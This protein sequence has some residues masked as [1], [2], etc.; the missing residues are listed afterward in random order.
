MK[1]I[2]LFTLIIVAVFVCLPSF[3]QAQRDPGG[4]PDAPTEVPFD[5]GLTLIIAAGAGY[6]IKKARDKRKKVLTDDTIEK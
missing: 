4:D 1:K 3:V 2:L 6:A 5:G